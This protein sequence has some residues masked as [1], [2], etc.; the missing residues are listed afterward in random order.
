[1]EFHSPQYAE[2]AGYYEQQQQWNG[3]AWNPYLQ[4]SDVIPAPISRR[5][6]G[7]VPESTTSRGRGF[8]R[9]RGGQI[10]RGRGGP[11]IGGRQ[12]VVAID[13]SARPHR[14]RRMDAEEA[15]ERAAGRH[16]RALRKASRE[17][18]SYGAAGDDCAAAFPSLHLLLQC[19]DASDEADATPGARGGHD[20]VLRVGRVGALRR[21]RDELRQR[22]AGHRRREKAQHCDDGRPDRQAS[23]AVPARPSVVLRPQVG[24][25][26]SLGVS[27]PM[28]API[29]GPNPRS[30]RSVFDRRPLI[31]SQ[32]QRVL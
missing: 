7:G 20:A 3:G 30:F 26:S 6:R 4:P 8:S 14:A 23:T 5:G 16:R 29:S 17:P 24:Q 22:A 19:C 12:E 28:P 9:G 18:P 11:A 1:M 27:L 15:A 21:T 25:G 10:G 2:P 32:Q 13:D 31:E